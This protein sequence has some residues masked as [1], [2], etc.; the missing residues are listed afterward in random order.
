R[1]Y[2]HVLQPKGLEK[3]NLKIKEELY[4]KAAR[5]DLACYD[6]PDYYNE[7]VLSVGEVQRRAGE[8]I[9]YVN[10]ISSNITTVIFV[11]GFFLLQDR[12]GMVFVAAAAT[13]SLLVGL[14]L[15]KLRFRMRVELNA[16]ERKRNYVNRVFYLADYAKELRLHD[17]TGK[18]DRD[19]RTSNHEVQA[20]IRRYS[21]RIT[22]LSFLS[23]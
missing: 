13:G 12:V 23:S 3:L 20:V 10:K 8:T 6:D 5:T 22:L 2:Y 7:F 15:N 17:V 14:A 16:K 4:A 19:F 9:D 11:S 21:G 18:L 1:V